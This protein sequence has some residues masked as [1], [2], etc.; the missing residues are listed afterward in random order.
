MSR[1]AETA[2]EGAPMKKKPKFKVGQ[3][4]C[5]KGYGS[6]YVRLLERLS[7]KPFT[8]G[9]WKVGPVFSAAK[10]NGIGHE[11]LMREL[12]ASEKGTAR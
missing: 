7:K 3:V 11:S 5:W 6:I 2:Q 12:T 4:V 9:F 10:K 8:K 1:Q